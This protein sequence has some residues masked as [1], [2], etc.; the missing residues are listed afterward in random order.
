MGRSTRLTPELADRIANLVSTGNYDV[1]VCGLVGIG[2]ST[3]YR[4]LAMGE[5]AKSGI[6]R[7]F[8]EKVKKA[9]AAR[10]AKWVKD[11][12][13]DPSWQSKAWLLER[14]YPD[15]WGRR[16]VD[17]NMQQEVNGQVS[18]KHD[19]SITLELAKDE[20]FLRAIQEAANRRTAESDMG[21]LSEPLGQGEDGGKAVE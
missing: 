17:V 4:W 16:T 13:A 19:G 5:K 21:G 2:T 8:W 6:Y 3:Y 12:D 10:E 9:E 20:E 7:E 18:V 15:R 14:R 1:V 11:I